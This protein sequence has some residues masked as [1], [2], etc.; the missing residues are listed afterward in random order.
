ML[1]TVSIVVINEEG[2]LLALKRSADRKWYPGKWDIVSG[3]IRDDETPEECF[4]R[5]IFEELG[6][7][8]FRYVKKIQMPYTYEED[9]GEWLVHSFLCKIDHSDIKLNEEHS[10]YK[11]VGLP[12]FLSLD[13]AK[14]LLVELGVFFDV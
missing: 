3:K 10:E 9:G 7:S 5:E 2:K 6:I 8:E 12:E 4:R 11:W 14:P 1:K 13:Y